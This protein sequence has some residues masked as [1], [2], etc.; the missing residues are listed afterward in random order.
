MPWLRRFEAMTGHG[1]QQLVMDA[2]GFRFGGGV[3]GCQTGEVDRKVLADG[4][5][6]NLQKVLG[7]LR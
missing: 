6:P 5:R 4:R 2:V 3:L 7:R 1:A